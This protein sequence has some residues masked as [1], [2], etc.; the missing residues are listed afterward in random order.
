VAN[1][2]GNGAD[3]V[4]GDVAAARAGL[5]AD[6]A[7]VNAVAVGTDEA[8]AAYYRSAVAG[9]PGAFVLEAEVSDRLVEAMLRKFLGDLVIAAR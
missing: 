3:N 5:L 7:T 1:L 9:G 2:I 8:V 6:G 4:G